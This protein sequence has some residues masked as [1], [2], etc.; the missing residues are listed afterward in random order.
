MTMINTITTLNIIIDFPEE[1]EKMIS[2]K[3]V[4][5][6]VKRVT[7]EMANDLAVKYQKSQRCK[8]HKCPDK[9]LNLF[10]ILFE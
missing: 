6:C 1:E 4:Q 8:L 2:Q 5:E 9:S 7:K 10:K 3:Q